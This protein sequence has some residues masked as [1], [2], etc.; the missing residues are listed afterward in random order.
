MELWDK[1]QKVASTENPEVWLGK[2]F[3]K[4]EL[5]HVKFNYFRKGVLGLK[6]D[7]SVWIFKLNL[8]KETL[9]DKINKHSITIKDIR[10]SLGD[11]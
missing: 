1:K 3:T 8:K 6:T 7:S 2:V 9:L 5:R 10:F 4:Q 11:M